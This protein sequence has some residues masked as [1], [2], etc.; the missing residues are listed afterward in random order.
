MHVM[1]NGPAEVGGPRG[2]SG[3]N[4]ARFD[5]SEASADA[6]VARATELAARVSELEATLAER[7]ATIARL[8]EDEVSAAE[9]VSQDPSTSTG[10]HDV[11][12]PEVA[13]ILH[14]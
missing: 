9:S 8:E 10:H 7:D 6:M 1:E 12:S 4:A 3:A 5:S 11:E 2:G 13:K 14:C